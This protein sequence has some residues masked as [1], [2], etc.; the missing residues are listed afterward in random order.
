M[1]ACSTHGAAVRPPRP[2]PAAVTVFPVSPSQD[3]QERLIFRFQTFLRD[4]IRSFRPSPQEVDYPA[5]LGAASPGGS[6]DPETGRAAA[7]EAQPEAH[8]GW[9]PT[10]PRALGCMA[11]VYRCVPRA[12]FEGLAQEAV[13][14]CTASLLYAAGMLRAKGKRLD[15]LLFEV[16]HLLALREQIAPFDIDFAVTEK[17]LDFSHTRQMLGTLSQ[18][19][20]SIGGVGAV[21][22]LL[23]QG[24]PSLVES[25]VDAKQRL[26]LKLKAACE[27]FILH[28]TELVVTPLLPFLPQHTALNLAT[29]ATTATAAAAAAAAPPEAPPTPEALHAALDAVEA[30]L[31]DGLRPAHALM[32]RYLPEPSTQAILFSPI[33]GNA[34]EAFG[35]LQTR[36]AYWLHLLCLHLL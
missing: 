34:L 23:Q 32:R 35:Q 27:A 21:V 18:R 33:K 29:A 36:Y 1:S 5:R 15:A 20:R 16:A 6:A 8:R 24:A 28:C 13:S 22:E 4:N 25:Q 31:R 19:R 12:V 10:L 17:V 14:D 26:E 11:R 30:G 7:A 9:Y 2:A 3:L